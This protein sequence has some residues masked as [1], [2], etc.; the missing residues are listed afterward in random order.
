MF[1]SWLTLLS[2]L[3][4]CHGQDIVKRNRVNCSSLLSVQIVRSVSM[5]ENFFCKSLEL[6][7]TITC[8]S[9]S[10]SKSRIEI[11]IS[12]LFCSNLVVVNNKKFL[13]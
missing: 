1:R 5:K 13:L 3:S 10:V 6:A 9:R 11:R 12:I 7:I 4:T 8:M 2:D